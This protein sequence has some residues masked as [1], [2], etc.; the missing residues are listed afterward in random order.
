[1][2]PILYRHFSVSDTSLVKTIG[3]AAPLKSGHW[4]L[5]DALGE[6]FGVRLEERPF[7]SDAGL[8]AWIRHE[9]DSEIRRRRAHSDCPSYT[10]IPDD[11][12][13]PCGMS[14][15]IEFGRHSA[16]PA[17]LSG[18]R[19][20][21][22][23][24]S[25]L[26]SLPLNLRNDIV[27]LASKGGAPFWAMQEVDGRQH[28][29]VASPLPEL[30][31]GEPLFRYF[32][33][34]E[35]LQLLPLILFLRNLTEDKRWEQPPLQACF[36]FDDPNLHWRTYGFVDFA[37]IAMHAER[38]RYHVSFATI[39]L[40][41]WFVH[42]STSVIFQQQRDQLS[43]LIH[44]ND[45][46]AEEFARPYLAEELDTKLW[47]ALRR[48]GEFERRSGVEVAR[49]MAPPHGACSESTLRAMAQLGFEAACVSRGS[50]HHYNKEATWVRTL[51]MRP[52]EMIGGGPVL[53]RFPLKRSCHNSILIAALLH[54]PVIA[55]GHHHDVAEGLHLLSDLAGFIDSIGT[56]RWGNMRQICR[57]HYARRL[58]GKSLSIR[59][60]TKRVEVCIPD[61]I[62]E[63]WVEEPRLRV[64]QSAP[65]LW[66]LLGERSGWNP[67][68]PDAPITVRPLQR[69]EIVSEFPTSPVIDA[70][71]GNGLRLWPMVRRQITEVRDRISPVLRRA[72]GFAAKAK[73]DRGA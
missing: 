10:I 23:E 56:V 67:H 48:I 65:F 64:A 25:K 26:Q 5:L 37:E 27:V 72:T 35:F 31:E 59:M 53:L 43:L 18:R 41:T 7:G 4:R 55:V 49:V 62:N 61:G 58:D 32:H 17:V 22:A 42:K 68:L 28:H 57:G 2:A 24:A 13:V 52:S 50:L 70:M 39:P 66:R 34:R 16:L 12:L 46:I 69:L 44:G 1:M 71:K 6:V 54:Q 63:L 20:E 33:G 14:S 19:V 8:D 45:H 15:T 60:F 21:A 38:H 73:I 40:D 47:Q 11:Q 3:I 36:M 51:G 29:Y 9:G 30:N